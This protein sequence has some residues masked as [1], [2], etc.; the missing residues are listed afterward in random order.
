MT[1]KLE[2]MIGAARDERC[3]LCGGFVSMS[4]PYTQSRQWVSGIPY[5]T[6]CGERVEWA[7]HTG[8]ISEKKKQ[9]INEYLK[10][11]GEKK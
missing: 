11:E 10:S 7:A 2:Q 6:P 3:Y 1:P 4:D 9:A 5:T 8:C